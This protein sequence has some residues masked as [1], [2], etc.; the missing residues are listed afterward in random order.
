MPRHAEPFSLFGVGFLPAFQWKRTLQWPHHAALSETK[1]L[2]AVVTPNQSGRSP[3][4]SVQHPHPFLNT[5]FLEEEAL[6]RASS[7]VHTSFPPSNALF[8]LPLITPLWC[9]NCCVL[10]LSACA[11]LCAHAGMFVCS[12][13]TTTKV[14]GLGHHVTNSR[15][16]LT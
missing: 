9:L 5:M 2:S 13:N 7:T 14:D 4:H 3:C 8:F 16:P 1:H 12:H 10:G 6:K 11:R 15:V